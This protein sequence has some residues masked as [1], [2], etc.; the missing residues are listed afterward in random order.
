MDEQQSYADTSDHDYA[1]GREERAKRVEILKQRLAEGA[2]LWTGE[3]ASGGTVGS[4][5]NGSPVSTVKPEVAAPAGLSSNASSGN[6]TKPKPA[7]KKTLSLISEGSFP[8]ESN[9][10]DS[11]RL[12]RRREISTRFPDCLRE[13][14]RALQDAFGLHGHV[15]ITVSN[16][17]GHSITYNLPDD[18][19][20]QPAAAKLSDREREIVRIIGQSTLAAKA[21]ASRLGQSNNSYLRTILAN[22]VARGVLGKAPNGYCVAGSP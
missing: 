8:S 18:L 13:L 11:D 6:G 2:D 17:A 16:S 20:E 9:R 7:A 12:S 5:R 15:T 4:A 1:R 3:P 21:I 22:L 14:C 10:R 19:A